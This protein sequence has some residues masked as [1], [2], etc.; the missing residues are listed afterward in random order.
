M[1][2]RE[3]TRGGTGGRSAKR[4]CKLI[5]KS[6]IDKQKR[7]LGAGTLSL[8][9]T[10]QKPGLVNQTPSVGM[11]YLPVGYW[12]QRPQAL[13]KKYKFLPLLLIAQQN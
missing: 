3:Q 2:T 9:M 11:G 6:V 1:R 10:P 5:L 7:S 8:L 13:P 4:R 12:L